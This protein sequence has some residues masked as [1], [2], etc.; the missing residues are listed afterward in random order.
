[1]RLGDLYP[2]TVSAPV[3]DARGSGNLPGELEVVLG[4]LRL[5]VLGTVKGEVGVASAT[6]PIVDHSYIAMRPP[7][8]IQLQRGRNDRLLGPRPVF[9]V[10]PNWDDCGRF[11]SE[12]EQ[13]ALESCDRLIYEAANLA[14]LV[15]WNRF[16]SGPDIATDKAR[17]YST[18]H[19]EEHA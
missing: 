7:R 11:K 5:A 9:N 19:Q 15:L 6:A 8:L 1:M 18:G 14:G 17:Q 12:V 16:F 2:D 3:F 4:F 10:R 13:L